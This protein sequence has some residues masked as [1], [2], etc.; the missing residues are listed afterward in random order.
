M[1]KQGYQVDEEALRGDIYRYFHFG[2]HIKKKKVN[3]KTVRYL[4]EIVEY[5]DG[6]KTN[7]VFEMKVE[8][9]KFIPQIGTYSNDFKNK[10]IEFGSIYKG[11]P[12]YNY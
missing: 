3:G 8:D 5:L 11:L 6:E 1:A 10:L 9:D 7:T 4:S 12:C 2:I